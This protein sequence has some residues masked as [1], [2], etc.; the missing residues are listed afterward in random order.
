[1]QTAVNLLVIVVA[2]GI[3]LDPYLNVVTS[4]TGVGTL[5]VTLLQVAAAASIGVYFGRRRRRE[6]MW[7]TLAAT[8][9]AFVGLSVSVVL[10]V[11]N[12][13]KLTG[14]SSPLVNSL[15]LVLVV[16]GLAGLIFG[17]W[18]GAKRPG[19]YSHIATDLTT[20][21]PARPIEERQ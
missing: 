14:V 4:M 9:V 2:V 15:P 3:G 8:A 6:R 10:L 13:E 16:I 1:M 7:G 12:F 19:V 21:T 5:G 18:L 11:M 20:S 17:F